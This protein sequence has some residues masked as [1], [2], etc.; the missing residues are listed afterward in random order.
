MDVFFA[1]PYHFWERSTNENTNGLSRRLYSKKSAFSG[2]GRAEIKRIDTFLNDRP[3]K[4]LGW[5]TPREKMAVFL[6]CAQ[7]RSPFS[8]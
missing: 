7:R 3:R 1:D 5:R 2:I 4:C 8:E 6:G